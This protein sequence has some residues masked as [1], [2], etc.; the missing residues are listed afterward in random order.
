M[1]QRGELKWNFLAVF[2][3]AVLHRWI[4]SSRVESNLL[5]RQHCKMDY[6]T[7]T[8]G[9]IV[10]PFFRFLFWSYRE[11]KAGETS[12]EGCS[13]K[14]SCECSDGPGLCGG[15]PPGGGL[16]AVLVPVCSRIYEVTSSFTWL[17]FL[18]N[19]QQPQSER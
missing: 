14:P 6:V 10:P 17:P 13:V 11:S 5:D 19:I 3:S 8:S 7:V 9:R 12:T 1:S 4:F 2:P 16:R 15:G 18:A